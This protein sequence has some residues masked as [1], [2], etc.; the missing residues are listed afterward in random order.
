METG[1]II[2][3]RELNEKGWYGVTHF[4]DCKVMHNYRDVSSA[5]LYNEVTQTVDFIY[6]RREPDPDQ[7]EIEFPE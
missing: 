3:L 7:L 6:T 2:T 4:A 5:L 1:Q